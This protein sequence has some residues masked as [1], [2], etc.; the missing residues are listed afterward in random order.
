MFEEIEEKYRDLIC[1][2]MKY[3]NSIEDKEHDI[4]HMYDVV[5][6]TKEILENGNIRVD[7][8]VCI[9]ASYWHDVG[10]IYGVDGHEK[11]SAEMLKEELLKN[12][13]PLEFID[14]CY[15][16]IEFH[17]WNMEPKTEEGLVVKDADK[18]AWLGKRRWNNCIKY[19]YKL[20]S[21]IEKLPRLR[22]E[23]L[24]YEISKKIYDREIVTFN[25]LL[26]M[27]S[28]L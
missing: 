27:N 25:R 3:M 2:S 23:I 14:K 20:D 8:E 4:N 19:K 15:K 17:K 5:E 28:F 16:A 18:L 1:I 7:K 22:N 13:Y 11:K 6:F 12:N 9:I 21:I 24:Y 26:K 10:R